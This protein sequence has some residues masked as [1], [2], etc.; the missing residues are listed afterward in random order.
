MCIRKSSCRPM[1]RRNFADRSA[2]WNSV[3]KIE[4]AKNSQLAR[5]I[6]IALPVEL[7]REKQIQLVREYVK[8]KFCVCWNV[9][10]FCHSR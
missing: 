5:E 1:R 4:K 9:R 3:E 2:L 8:E 10:R 6:E 7:D